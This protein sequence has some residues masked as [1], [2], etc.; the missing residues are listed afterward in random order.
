MR[1]ERMID[2]GGAGR[3]SFFE[4][5]TVR[6][7][8]VILAHIGLI[9]RV[10]DCYSYDQSTLRSW[11]PSSIGTRTRKDACPY[12]HFSGL[13]GAKTGLSRCA[14]AT[15]VQVRTNQRDAGKPS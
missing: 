7:T 12:A 6:A 15:H 2:Q 11:L 3:N 5:D 1:V 9:V 10:I 8:V 4:K 14:D 13:A